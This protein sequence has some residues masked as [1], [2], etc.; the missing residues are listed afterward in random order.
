MINGALVCGDISKFH[1]PLPVAADRTTVGYGFA[2]PSLPAQ[3]LGTP[4]RTLR[5]LRAPASAPVGMKA[6]AQAVTS[7]LAKLADVT[8]RG[9]K[10]GLGQDPLPRSV[11]LSPL[12]GLPFAWQCAPPLASSGGPTLSAATPRHG[13]QLCAAALADD[14]VALYDLSLREWSPHKLVHTQQRGV[15]SLCWQP[16]SASILAVG[17]ARGVCIWRLTFAPARGELSGGHM[18]RLLEAEGHSP[19]RSLCWHPHGRWLASASPAQGALHVWDAADAGSGTPLWMLRGGLGGGGV[20]LLELSRCGLLLLAACTSGGLRIWESR[21]WQWESWRRFRVPCVAAAWSGPPPLGPD[22]ARTL[23]IALQVCGRGPLA[24]PLQWPRPLACILL[25]MRMRAPRAHNV[26]GER[27]R[28]GRARRE[29][30]PA[31]PRRSPATPARRAKPPCTRSVS[32]RTV[33]S[34]P[35]APLPPRGAITSAAMTSRRST[36]GD[37]TCTRSCTLLYADQANGKLC[38]GGDHHHGIM[39]VTQYVRRPPPRSKTRDL[40]LHPPACSSLRRSPAPSISTLEW[41]PAANRLII[42]WAVVADGSAGAPATPSAAAPSAAA[43]ATAARRP[44][45]LSVMAT[46][47]LPTLQMH[48]VGHAHGHARGATL[49][50]TSL[51]NACAA[52][53]RATPRH[54]TPH[55][56]RPSHES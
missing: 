43:D 12:D 3:P 40:P 4:G 13:G 15:E 47:T 44:P 11:P 10:R 29:R 24:P 55:H 54:A 46:R 50:G 28:R 49:S 19:V 9:I 39:I 53:R 31:P 6:A 42:G 45:E 20:H 48:L 8:E 41:T 17:C 7:A 2:L 27:A 30:R 21:G 14:S 22:T 36:A 37:V 16:Q 23:L 35:P 5:P 25:L 1:V 56:A 33:R 18:L 38:R 51:S 34:M 26:R 52:P 32:P